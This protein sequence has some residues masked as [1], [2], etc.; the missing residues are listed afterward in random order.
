MSIINSTAPS[1]WRAY[2]YEIGAGQTF[3]VDAPDLSSFKSTKYYIEMSTVS[4]TV[5]LE[6]LAAQTVPGT[7]VDTVYG[8]IGNGISTQ[9]SFVV[10]GINANLVIKNN[11]ASTISVKM[12][13]LT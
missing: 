1:I 2:K 9:I 7:V 5:A 6:M 10:N 3:I 4:N 11:E 13:K 12:V 8:R